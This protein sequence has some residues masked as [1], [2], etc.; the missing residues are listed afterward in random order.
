MVL[1]DKRL[2]FA[3]GIYRDDSDQKVKQESN[4]KIEKRI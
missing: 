1:Q 2:T 3:V 4:Y